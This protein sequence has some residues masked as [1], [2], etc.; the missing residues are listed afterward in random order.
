M[1]NFNKN[2]EEEINKAILEWLIKKKYSSVIDPF[3]NDT[4]LK[5]DNMAKDN[6]L[7]RKWG[8]IILL[9]K[10]VSDLENQIKNLTEELSTN[11]STLYNKKDVESFVCF[12]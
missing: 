6:I 11:L 5:S 10:K 1:D 12:Y 7:E 4:G 8:T 2:R 9:Q 3:L